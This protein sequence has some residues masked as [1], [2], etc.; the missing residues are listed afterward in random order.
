MSINKSKSLVFEEAK[1]SSENIPEHI[2]IIMDGNR[3]WA[4][5]KGLPIM[6]GHWQ[7]AET[8]SKII[9]K[10]ASLGVKVLTVYAFSTENWN[11]NFEEIESL[12]SLFQA[13]LIGQK[14]RMIEEGVRLGS[15]GDISRFPLEIQKTLLEVK[16]ATANGNKIDLVLAINY[17]ARDDIRRA[18]SAIVEDCL[19][20]KLQKNEITEFL[21]S[22]Y[23]DTAPWK[24]P[25]LLI[26]TS[27]EQRLSNFLLWQL[28]YTEIYSTEV[29]W[30]DFNEQDLVKA[31]E[32]YQH[33][34]RRLGC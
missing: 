23:L 28:S 1:A 17:G 25:E 31:I 12:M 7:G 19:M 26:R 24:D 32:I 27:G 6:V 18:T 3:R 30:P 34:K 16:N 10:A 22:Q 20:G 15:I 14:N 8:L 11:R 33:R 13:Y 29:L 21:I 2:A 5:D 4:Q 9:E